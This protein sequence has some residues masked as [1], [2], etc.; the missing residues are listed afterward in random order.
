[1][2]RFVLQATEV[3]TRNIIGMWW[4]MT[5]RLWWTS[6][7]KVV[8]GWLF[9]CEVTLL[10]FKNQYD[11]VSPV[12]LHHSSSVWKRICVQ[13][14]SELSSSPISVTYVLGNQ[15]RSPFSSPSHQ[16][17]CCSNTWIT[18][19]LSKFRWLS[20][21]A[22]HEQRAWADRLPTTFWLGQTL[23]EKERK[24]CVHTVVIKGS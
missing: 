18:S 9:L 13:T 10:Y 7:T 1:M 22:V 3:Y 23:R 14:H 5:L 15:P 24:H 21:F 16:F 4:I 19:S 17:S 11:W 8:C 2:N 6:G 12:P 20:V